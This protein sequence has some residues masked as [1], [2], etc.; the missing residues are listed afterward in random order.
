MN[1]LKVHMR[2]TSALIIR[3]MAARFGD[4]PGGYVWALLDPLTHVFLM[5]IIFSAIAKVPP[6]GSS[7][8]LFFASGYLCFQFYQGMSAYVAS[9]VKANKSLLT[10]PL[11]APIDAV[12]AR[13]VLQFVTTSFVASFILGMIVVQQPY[14]VQFDWSHLLE[15]LFAATLLGAG[16]GLINVT[17][18]ARSPLYEQI[19]S[20]I[21]R[22]MFMVSGV[23]FLP[24]A[25][26][27][28]YMDY[29]LYNPILHAVMCF[30]QGIYPE[31]QTDVLDMNYLY[32]WA[33][34]TIFIG[35]VL[36]SVSAAV[37]SYD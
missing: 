15:A 6:L 5:T 25:M 31:Y 29:L 22:P 14:P 9:A 20:L 2:V 32:E 19:F 12:A 1:A 11:V 10:Y 33:F 34:G 30:R 17:L 27:R 21:N 7:F 3:E 13:Y 16:M 36:L 28:P 26:P 37:L 35:L 24:D 4:K 8:P 18:F 23:F